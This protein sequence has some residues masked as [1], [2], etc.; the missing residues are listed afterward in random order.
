MSLHIP[1]I[2]TAIVIDVLTG[3]RVLR[4][5][6]S[7]DGVTLTEDTVPT[8]E[9]ENKYPSLVVDSTKTLFKTT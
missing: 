1:D 8:I 6:T 3:K 9:D 2:K 4:T 7:I 5:F